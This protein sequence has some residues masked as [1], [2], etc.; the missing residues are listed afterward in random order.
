L[1][2]LEVLLDLCQEFGDELINRPAESIP[3]VALSEAEWLNFEDDPLV[4][5]E[6][7][8]AQSSGLAMSAMMAVLK[9]FQDR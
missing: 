6:A 9:L 5:T 4:M 8:R 2:A 7:E 3:R 1:A